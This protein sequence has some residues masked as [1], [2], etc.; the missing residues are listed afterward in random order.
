MDTIQ[1]SKVHIPRNGIEAQLR[2]DNHI[3]SRNTRDI[4]SP[5]KSNK[6]MNPIAHVLNL[7]LC[8]LDYLQMK[9]LSNEFYIVIFVI[10]CF[11]ITHKRIRQG[12]KQKY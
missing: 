1:F 8:V 6:W 4:Y 12:L 2:W 3:V 7:I 11:V 5:F 9:M 10:L